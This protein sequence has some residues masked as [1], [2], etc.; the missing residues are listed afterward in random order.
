MRPPDTQPTAACTGG[1]RTVDPRA[2]AGP[3][4]DAGR[5]PSPSELRKTTVLELPLAEASAKVRIGDLVDEPDD[6]TG[7]WWAGVVSVTTR[8]GAPVASADST[9]GGGPPTAVA[10]LAGLTPD[11]RPRPGRG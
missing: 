6:I 3:V 10:A 9:I 5:P 11:T 2:A 7:P 4:W 8:F 1:R